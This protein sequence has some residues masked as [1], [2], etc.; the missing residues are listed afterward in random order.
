LDFC[1]D[2]VGDGDINS[3]VGIYIGN[4]FEDGPTIN[5]ET[6]QGVRGRA[7]KLI[8]HPEYK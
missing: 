7:V 4:G 8:P 2:S 6:L 1:D 5:L 3:L